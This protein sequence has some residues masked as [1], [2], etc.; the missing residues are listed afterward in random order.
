MT[1][2]EPLL[3]HP[4]AYEH[5]FHPLASTDLLLSKNIYK[6]QIPVKEKLEQFGK[7]T[8][9]SSMCNYC[10]WAIEQTLCFPVLRFSSLCRSGSN[11]AM[12]FMKRPMSFDFCS[13]SGRRAHMF[14]GSTGFV[15]H[16]WGR[17]HFDHFSMTAITSEGGTSNHSMCSSRHPLQ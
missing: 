5:S 16:G 10:S 9:T 11:C 6:S 4:G 3:C 7:P 8:L 17:I 15:W 13:S 12:P 1:V 14:E 2:I